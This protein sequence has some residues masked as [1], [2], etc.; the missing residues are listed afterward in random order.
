M[1]MQVLR[2]SAVLPVA[3]LTLVS[4][5]LC[6]PGR[7]HQAEISSCVR[8]LADSDAAVR[9]SAADDLGRMGRGAVAAVPALVDLLA[10][11][12]PFVSGMAADALGRIGAAGVPRLIAALRD[13]ETNVRWGAAIALGKIGSAAGGAV[14]A[15][16]GALR[17]TDDNV[18]WSA[19]I[20]LGSLGTGAREAV[21]A[22]VECLHDRDEDVRWA[23]D[24]AL[25]GIDTLWS[26][27][28]RDWRAEVSAIDSLVP[29]LMKEL[30]VPGVSIA[31]IENRGIVWSGEY[32]VADVRRGTPVTRETLFEAASMTKPVFA[33]TVMKLAD[34]GTIDLDRPLS[35]YLHE[36]TLPLQPARALITARMVLSHTAGLPNWR[37]G[38]E[39]R[40]GPL[41]VYFRPGSRFSYSGEG[42]YY[43]QRAVERITGQPIAVLAR[44]TLFDP[45][46]MRRTSY[47]WT[48][49]ADSLIAAGHTAGGSFLAK[50]AY[51]H[52]NAAY[53]LYTNAREYAAFLVEI[54]KTDRSSP[55]SVTAASVGAMLSH[56]VA[57]DSRMPV[58][59]PGRARGDA[60]YWGLGWSVNTT[61]EGDIIHHSGSNRSGFRSFCQFS[62]TRGSGLVILTNS[63]RGDELWARIVAMAG[64]L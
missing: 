64:D 52:A 48:K 22:L 31:V 49:N 56:I 9:E 5:A 26:S 42:I 63:V 58:G 4:G 36:R 34:E 46:G 12:D 35:E 16:T 29:A 30:H 41:P 27:R 39:E 47:V 53:T 60:V 21:P 59:R 3:L 15:L 13:G 40:G 7:G 1:N 2:A 33:Y 57:V 45:L 61:G 55:A 62:P 20:A 32:G 11:R 6:Q 51:T 37:K 50:T 8:A 43:L 19:A 44:R 38:E 25:G 10:D 54:L 28:V 24:M 14:S 18:R 17:D 23:A